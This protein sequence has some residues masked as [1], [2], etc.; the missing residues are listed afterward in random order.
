MTSASPF[1][2]GGADGCKAGW[3]LAGRTAEGDIGLEVHD[4]LPSVLARVQGV[5]ALDMP[6]GLPE[7]PPR[8]CDTAARKLLGPRRSS[9]F[10]APLRD[11]LEAKTYEDACAMGRERSGRGLSLQTWNLMPKVR[12]VDQ[13][14]DDETRHRVIEVHPEVCFQGMN[15]MTPLPYAKKSVEGHAFRKD[16][17]RRHLGLWPEDV[18]LPGA[19][20]D[21]VLDALAAMWTACRHTEGLAQEVGPAGQ[22]DRRGLEMQIRW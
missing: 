5:L 15:D 3:T 21:D 10:A 20:R 22:H 16:L 17:L 12:D 18:R 6:I 8:A 2:H 4:T 9:V 14:L 1:L 7:A 19:A 13:A 11:M